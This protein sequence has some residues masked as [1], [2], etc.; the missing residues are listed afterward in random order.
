MLALCSGCIRVLVE[1][2]DSVTDRQLCSSSPSI[3]EIET[4]E[5]LRLFHCIELE[6]G[7]D[8]LDGEAKAIK[9]LDR[10]GN[11]ARSEATELVVIQVVDD[12]DGAAGGYYSLRLADAQLNRM[13]TRKKVSS[14]CVQA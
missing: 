3:A 10:L 7:L 1:H 4:Q 13:C 8:D 5:S 14:R 12:G 9:R 11:V 6:L 2:A